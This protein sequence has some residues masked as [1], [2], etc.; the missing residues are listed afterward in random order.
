MKKPVQK[1][2]NALTPSP[3]SRPYR[4]YR[5]CASYFHMYKKLRLKKTGLKL[6]ILKKIKSVIELCASTHDPHMSILLNKWVDPPF[7]LLFSF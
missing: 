5:F 7:H 2:G 4:T 6:M 1:N 3:T